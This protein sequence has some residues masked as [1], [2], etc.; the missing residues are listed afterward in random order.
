MAEQHRGRQAT[1]N[2][3]KT[4]RYSLNIGVVIKERLEKYGKEHGIDQ[5]GVVRMA[6]DNFLTERGY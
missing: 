1:D 6:L 2:I 5:A 3:V 4:E